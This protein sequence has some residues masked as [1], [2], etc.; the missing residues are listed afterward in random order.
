MLYYGYSLKNRYCL[1][2]EIAKAVSEAI[3][4][5]VIAAVL[6]LILSTIQFIKNENLEKSS[7]IAL[8]SFNCICK[9][10]VLTII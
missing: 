9:K 4:K 6:N 2:N 7:K 1:L 5:Y 8:E 3:D 10:V